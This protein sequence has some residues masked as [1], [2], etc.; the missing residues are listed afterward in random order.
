MMLSRVALGLLLLCNTF[1]L[2]GCL[3]PLQLNERALVQ[4]VGVDWVRDHIHL[5]LQVFSPAAEG[6]NGISAS[7]QNANIIESDGRTVTEA[8]QNASLTQGK[9]MFIGHNRVIIVGEELAS[10]GIAQAIAYFSASSTA[11]HNA[12]L[13]IAKGSA[14]D[15][16]SAKI[17]QGILPAETLERILINA[18]KSGL[19]EGVKLY[20]F[21][22]A[23]QNKHDSAVLPVLAR[24]PE[25]ES[26]E[27]AAPQEGKSPKENNVEN[28]SPIYVD[29]M[30]V[31]VDGKMTDILQGQE[32]RGLLWLRGKVKDTVI[33][34][35]SDIYQNAALHVYWTQSKLLPQMDNKGEN[36]SFVLNVR[37]HATLKETMLR[38][39]V[40][41]EVMLDHIKELG[42][43]AEKLITA[44]VEE[45]FKKTVTE[46]GADIFNLGNIIWKNDKDIW[47]A[48]RSNWS[49]KLKDIKL[50][51]NAEVTVD[52]VGSELER[53]TK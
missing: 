3:Q 36:I 19:F 31:F 29:G 15:I 41:E 51:V 35:Q 17:N 20:E 8:F 26:A 10:R 12:N 33:T 4:A 32:V 50:T 53:A 16:V 40:E 38:E 52:R 18:E 1:L 47:K 23:L 45:A 21:M 13:V 5:T 48:V 14:K 43:A 7:P 27:A 28:V 9:E 30:A 37:C 42:T 11:R 6:G 25:E 44:E 49:E 34:V 2:S 22:T 24:K 39:G 46:D